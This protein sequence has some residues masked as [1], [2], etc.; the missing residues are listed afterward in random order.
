MGLLVRFAT[1]SAP[2]PACAGA[3]GFCTMAAIVKIFVALPMQQERVEPTKSILRPL[4]GSQRCR[5]TIP[6]AHFGALLLLDLIGL[7]VLDLIGLDV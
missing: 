1:S 5:A 4:R 7:D 6:I 3:S 2:V